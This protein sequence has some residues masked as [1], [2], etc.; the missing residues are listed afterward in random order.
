[1]RAKKFEQG[2]WALLFDSKF[3]DFQGKFQT[4]RLGPYEIDT[5]FDT[6]AVKIKAIDNEQIT[7]L[8]NG[9]RL[10]LYRKPL[11]REEF[12]KYLQENYECKLVK[13]NDS[14]PHPPTS[15]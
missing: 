15:L 3:K 5:I 7:F 11:T 8:V 13:E 6:G 14:S 1:M 4:H 2:D 12:V 9:N 10:R